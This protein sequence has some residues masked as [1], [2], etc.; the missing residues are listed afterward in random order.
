ME[1]G[2]EGSET[3]RQQQ[4]GPLGRNKKSREATLER[5]RLSGCIWL[6]RGGKEGHSRWGT[7]FESETMKGWESSSSRTE[8]SRS[9]T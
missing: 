7:G 9:I 1:V 6:R 8:D 3:P 5:G 2:I 4:A